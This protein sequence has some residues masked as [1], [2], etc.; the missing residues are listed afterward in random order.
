MKD[1]GAT[2]NYVGRKFIEEH[3][4]EGAALHVKGAGRM[5]VETPNIKADDG[6]EQDQRAKL[7]LRLG[8]LYGYEAEF[9]IDDVKRFYIVLGKRWMRDINRR[10]QIDH[11]SNEIWIADNLWE[12]TEDGRVHSLPGLLPLHIDEGIAGQAKFMGIHSMLKEEYKNVSACL[13][14]QAFLIKVH[15]RGYGGTLQ[16]NKL[17]RE[18]PEMLT[19]FQGLFAKTT[20]GNSRSGRQAHFVIE[21]EPIG[22]IPFCSPYCISPMKEAELRRQIDKAICCR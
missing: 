2:E 18:F 4:W 12:E 21:T 20:F 14:K 9:T 7:K 13:L 19:E 3:T 11:D 17:P 22:E 16:P 6:I 5:I 1:D 15:H 8:A 10:N